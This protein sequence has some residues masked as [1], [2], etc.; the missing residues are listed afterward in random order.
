MEYWVE[1]FWYCI[2]FQWSRKNPWFTMYHQGI[3]YVCFCNNAESGSTY[4]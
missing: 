4:H 2:F 3:W 1:N